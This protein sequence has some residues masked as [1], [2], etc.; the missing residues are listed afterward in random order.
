MVLCTTEPFLRVSKNILLQ[1]LKEDQ[2]ICEVDCMVA[3]K[4]IVH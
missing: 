1:K 3:G 4:D 2:Q